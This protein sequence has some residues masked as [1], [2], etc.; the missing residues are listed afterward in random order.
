MSVDEEVRVG[1]LIAGEA[2]VEP[3]AV[4]V[5]ADDGRAH[6]ELVDDAAARDVERPRVERRL[7]G[8]RDRAFDAAE[9]VA[10]VRDVRGVDLRRGRARLQRRQIGV[11]AEHLHEL[12]GVELG[13]AELI[14]QRADVEER[15]ERDPSS[16]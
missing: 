15:A 7:D 2:E 11:R 16:R 5:E 14:A 9:R 12:R 1:E 8:R 6:R 10:D 4:Q 3:A 13:L